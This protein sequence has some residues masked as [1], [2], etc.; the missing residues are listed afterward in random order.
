MATLLTPYGR[1]PGRIVGGVT[2][3]QPGPL[4]D[5][6]PAMA[7]DGA[8]GY[9]ATPPMNFT[10]GLTLEAWVWVDS[11]NPN[12]HPNKGI[13]VQRVGGSAN[14]IL[15]SYNGNGWDIGYQVA[16]NNATDYAW[17]STI[18]PTQTWTH[19]VVTQ[20]PVQGTV[21]YANVV[22]QAT[23]PTWTGNLALGSAPFWIGYDFWNAPYRYF[24]GKIAQ[25]AVY[26]YA[27]QPAQI[28]A[29]YNAR[30]L[31]QPGAYAAVVLADRPA[32]YWPLTDASG[33]W[34]HDAVLRP[35]A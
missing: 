35:A 28:Q 1:N 6:S 25:A 3:G 7:F 23:Q 5:G 8:T 13:L 19:A 31:T 27:L 21:V 12:T 32:A 11:T 4:A 20:D 34:A 33:P 15:A 16:P 29:H 9:I 22:V 2:L 14:E 26:D 18:L 17:T 24:P 10:G 30:T